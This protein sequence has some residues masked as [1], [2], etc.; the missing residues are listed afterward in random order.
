ME[1]IDINNEKPNR[2]EAVL[3]TVDYIKNPF[4]AMY[5]LNGSFEPCTEHLRALSDYDYSDATIAPE[6]DVFSITHWARIPKK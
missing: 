1:W 5:R 3:V 4:M 6:Y 2:D